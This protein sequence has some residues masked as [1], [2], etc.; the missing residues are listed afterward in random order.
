MGLEWREPWAVGNDLPD[1]DHKHLVGLT[2]V[3]ENLVS[4]A[5]IRP[6]KAG[7]TRLF[8]GDSMASGT[9]ESH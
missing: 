6:E 4:H 5:K 8:S 7:A 9:S 1:T 3:L 2:T